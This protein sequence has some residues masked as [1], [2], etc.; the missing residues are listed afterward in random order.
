MKTTRGMMKIITTTPLKYVLRQMDG[1][2]VKSLIH[3]GCMLPSNW[4][5]LSSTIK[6]SMQGRE[7]TREMTQAATTRRYGDHGT[8]SG[9]VMARCLSRVIT[10]SM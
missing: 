5:C 6:V 2:P 1:Q 9:L 10:A 7:G 3:S 8:E 4:D